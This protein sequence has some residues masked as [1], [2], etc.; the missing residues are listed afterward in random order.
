MTIAID[1]DEV[2]VDFTGEAA[3]VFEAEG[4]PPHVA[5]GLYDV[6]PELTEAQKKAF[7]T[8]GER[9]ATMKAFG[10]AEEVLTELR[11]LDKVVA[12]TAPWK[13]SETWHRARVRHL[14]E[15]GFAEEEIIFCPSQ[16]K[17]FFAV[18][19]LVEDRTETLVQWAKRNPLAT[20]ICLATPWNTQETPALAELSNAY[21]AQTPK[22]IYRIARKDYEL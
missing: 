10:H 18:D 11:K 22:D 4:L 7:L 17:P 19:I 6:Y 5:S 14:L 16:L 3:A 2:L 1:V 21:L 8:L 15:L 9:A 12:L 20:G 13:G